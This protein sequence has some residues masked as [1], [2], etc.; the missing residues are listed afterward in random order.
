MKITVKLFAIVRDRAGTSELKLD[1]PD[2]ATVD[3]VAAETA[4]QYP[5]IDRFLQRA[6]YAVNHDYVPRST[7]LKDQDEVAIIPPVSGGMS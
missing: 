6:A 4:R 3:D 1:L 7:R 5:A 2:G